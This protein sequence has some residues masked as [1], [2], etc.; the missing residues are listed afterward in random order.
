MTILT[1]IQPSTWGKIKMTNKCV[2][3]GCDREQGEDGLCGWHYSDSFYMYVVT[4]PYCMYKHSFSREMIDAEDNNVKNL[5]CNNCHK[6]FE[7]K[8][9]IEIRYSSRPIFEVNE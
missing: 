6:K 4:C 3:V 5:F 8:V 7:C 2:R 1:I 9:D